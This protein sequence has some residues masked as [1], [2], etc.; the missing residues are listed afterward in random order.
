VGVEDVSPE[1]GLHYLPE[2]FFFFALWMVCVCVG[3]C[4]AVMEFSFHIF[5]LPP[6]FWEDEPK[7]IT[8]DSGFS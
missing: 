3:L 1:Q 8:W 4:P 7:K 5:S 2:Y 6:I